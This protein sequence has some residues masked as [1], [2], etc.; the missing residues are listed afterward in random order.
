MNGDRIRTT[1]DSLGALDDAAR[2]RE[3]ESLEPDERMMLLLHI[4]SR[5]ASLLDECSATI[6]HVR[7]EARTYRQSWPRQAVSSLGLLIG[8]AVAVLF[9]ERVR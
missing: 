4:V 5:Q 6:E 3:F 1:L 9:G 7:A 2:E 8:G